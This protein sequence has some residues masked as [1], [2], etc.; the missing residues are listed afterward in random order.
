MKTLI[1][2]DEEPAA[3]R[4]KK[5]LTE[6]EPGIQITGVIVSIKSAVE[7]LQKNAMPDLILMDVHLADG[8]SFDIFNEVTVTCPVIFITAFNQY[9]LKSF[10]VNGI[11]YLLKPVKKQEL[12]RAIDKFKNWFQHKESSGIDYL[13]LASLIQ[14]NDRDLK[15]RIMI[16]YGE[17]IKTIEISDVAYFFTE[18]KINF[19]RTKSNVTYPIDFNLDEMES[20]IDPQKFFRINRQF[21]VNFEAIAKMVSFSKSRVKITLNPPSDIE[22]IVSTERSGNFKHWLTGDVS[23]QETE[24]NL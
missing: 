15:K 1:I 3:V 9:A 19:L 5:M 7:W 23:K 18:D 20:R 10:Q 13:K 8:T 24:E 12:E 21:I 22:T 16:R 6:I 11:D 2:E 17:V 4:L 14:K